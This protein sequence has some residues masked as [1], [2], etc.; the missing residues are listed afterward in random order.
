LLIQASV[1][2]MM[3]FK[4]KKTLVLGKVK[5]ELLLCRRFGL[6]RWQW[7]RR[8]F[9]KIELEPDW[10]LN[11][12]IMITGES[13]AGKSNVCK[14]ILKQL[15]DSGT[16]F[17][18]LDPHAEY[19][20]DAKEMRAAVYDAGMYAVNAFDLDGLTERERTS[21][22]TA[23][24]RRIMHLGEVQAST[25]YR[26]ISYTYWIAE[27]KGTVPNMRS[28]LYTIKVFR[29]RARSRQEANVLDGLEKRLLV[30]A[31]E[32][33]T[34]SVSMGRVMGS[35]S[36]FSL[37]SL[38]SSESQS[39]YMESMLRKVYTSMLTRSPGARKAFYVV[40][41]EAEKL[42]DSPVIARL[43]AEGR[44]YGIGL[45]A[46]SQRAKAL[47]KEIRSNA[48]TVIA[49]AQREPEEQ[50]YVANMIAGGTEYNRFVEVRKALRELPRGYAL[51]Q[52]A[53]EENP[54]IVKCIRL[55]A[56]TRDPGHR[57]M[58]MARGA[59]SKREMMERL[60]REGFSQ[61]EMIE[62]VAELVRAGMLKYHVV[63][64]PPYQGVWYIAMP[65]NSA[66]HD[67]MVSLIS[68][69]LTEN[70][71]RNRIYNNSYGPDVIAY[72]DGKRIAVEYET[73]MKK[74][75]ETEEMLRKRRERYGGVVVL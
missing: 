28:L 21:E 66:E 2:A 43:V 18:V 49:F 27:R 24:F 1:I 4:N 7:R 42:Q 19:V 15:A 34:K 13:G 56:R 44:K 60:E 30:V 48:A 68:R 40:I 57:I 37:Q 69:Y 25:L 47:D 62:S 31:G 11:R 67:V 32:G 9:K 35:R 65:R 20:E 12:H 14:L 17:V 51:V 63:T 16:D 23:M 70:G 50:S 41:D 10:A 29:L 5:R 64:E 8:F 71:I 36:I 33:F 22:I 53:R 72:K 3:F 52:E 74:A 59:V 46:I 39:V 58:E 55:K 73:G 26:C 38:H 45:I 61:E 54:K 6:I 75:E